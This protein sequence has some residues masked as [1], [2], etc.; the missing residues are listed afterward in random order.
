MAAIIDSYLDWCQKH[1]APDTYEWYRY[2]LQRFVDCAPR[3][4][5]VTQL[6]PFHVQQWIDSYQGL[7]SGSKRN[8]CR[9]IQ[10]T[11]RWA[12]QQGYI[13]H[14]PIAHMEKPAGGK[15]EQVVSPEEYSQILGCTRDRE[16]RDLV[17]TSWET[18][19]RPQESLRVEARHV[20]LEQ[21]RWVFPKSEEKM[22][23]I[24]RIV[25]LTD[26]ALEI[27]RRLMLA[28]PEG[29][30]FRNTRGVP[31][32]A[33]AVNC[34]FTTIRR[35]LGKRY[36]LYVLRHTW[37]NRLLTAGVDSLTVAVLAGHCDTSTLAKT[38]QHRSQDP[39]VE[40]GQKA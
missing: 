13:E 20:D 32:T 36:C 6:K 10:R 18:G 26:E 17:I 4:L 27:T 2:R 33:D 15:R 7:S 21:S 22:G 16:F 24:T 8:Y 23:R 39:T 19:C 38:Y 31:W 37:M 28:H 1:R 11:M 25:Y 34:R 29:R 5:R 9:A 35:K 12:E 40:G 14:S 3:D 30:L